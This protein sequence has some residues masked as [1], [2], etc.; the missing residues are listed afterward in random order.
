MVEFRFDFSDVIRT[1]KMLSHSRR[2][3]LMFALLLILVLFVLK[4]TIWWARYSI[5]KDA[6]IAESGTLSATYRDRISSSLSTVDKEN[7]Y[8]LNNHL[9]N[10]KSN[11]RVIPKVEYEAIPKLTEDDV[12]YKWHMDSGAIINEEYK[13]IFF[14]V[15]KAASSEWKLFLMR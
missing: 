11:W 6:H 13:L 3:S 4:S 1:L 15:A 10:G 9:G 12:I 5:V 14:S 8:G 7:H 2:N